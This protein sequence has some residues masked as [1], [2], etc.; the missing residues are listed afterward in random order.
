[1]TPSARL[2]HAEVE[3]VRR[4]P[5]RSLLVFLTDRCPVGCAHCSVDSL[6]DS[7][8]ITD[9]ELFEAI[10]T[11]IANRP[12]LETVG[13]SGGEPFVERRGLE[14]ASARFRAAGLRQ[15]VFT[16]GVWAK[17]RTA[18]WIGD[19][20]AR[21]ETVYLSTDAFHARAIDDAS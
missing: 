1:M 13:I 18:G 19:T 17:G 2:T 6:R 7:P 3:S 8:T 9:F 11:W 14:L 12:G 15:V 4:T 21:C 16:S 10:V 20:L 5:G